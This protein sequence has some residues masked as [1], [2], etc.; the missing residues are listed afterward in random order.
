MVKRA[1]EL[2]SDGS[3]GTVVASDTDSIVMLLADTTDEME[4]GVLCACTNI[5]CDQV[6]DLREIQDNIEESKDSV[7]FCH[8]VYDTATFFS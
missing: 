5:K 3:N 8:A 6:N 1:L 7:I 2:A 4:M